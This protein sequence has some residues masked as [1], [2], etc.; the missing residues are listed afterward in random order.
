[1]KK[2]KRPKKRDKP[3]LRLMTRE[4]LSSALMEVLNFFLVRVRVGLEE[5]RVVV[6]VVV[7]VEDVTVGTVVV[8]VED[9]TVVTVV[10]LVTL[11][12][13]VILKANGEIGL[14]WL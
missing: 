1:M 2:T 3:V 4:V 8:M 10:D 9:V 12:E 14:D 7:T 13:V 5:K 6:V 11:G